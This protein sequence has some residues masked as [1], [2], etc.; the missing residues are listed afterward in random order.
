MYQFFKTSSIVI[1]LVVLALSSGLTTGVVS[2]QERA[3]IDPN[4][5]VSED[6]I[7]PMPESV[8]TR[9]Q[10][11]GRGTGETLGTPMIIPDEELNVR[12]LDGGR[13]GMIESVIGTDS[14]TKVTTTTVY[15]SRAIAYLYI[16]F[17]N[18]AAGSCTGWFIDPNTLATAGH[19][20]Y[21]KGDG[22]WAK[23]IKVYPGANGNSAPYGYTVSKKLWSVTGWTT[24]TNWEYDYGAIQTTSSLGTTVGWFGLRWQSSN[25]FSGSYTVRGYPG[26]KPY[27]TMWTMSGSVYGFQYNSAYRKLWYKMDTAGGQSGSPVYHVY[28]SSCCYGVAIHAYG[29]STISGSSYNSGTRITQAVYNNLVA[30]KN[31]P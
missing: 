8:G 17:P 18:N 2:A 19:C 16:V 25:T 3:D 24:S 31:A 22:G 9:I 21:S 6:G 15:P 10:K 12:A 26:D 5:P 1:L 7:L 4:T 30:W 14:R 27:R 20:V 11:P 29:A 13:E 23:S 28:N